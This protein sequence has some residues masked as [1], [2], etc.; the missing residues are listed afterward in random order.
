MTISWETP[1]SDGGCEILG[2]AVFVDDGA[3]GA[4]TEVNTDSDPDVRNNPGLH[5][6]VITSPF[7]DSST[8]GQEFRVKVLCYNIEGETFSDTASIILGDVPTA[9]ADP[10]RKI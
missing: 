1:S 5:E 9:P 2:Y 8:I 6:L 10:V 3:L 7:T 4:F